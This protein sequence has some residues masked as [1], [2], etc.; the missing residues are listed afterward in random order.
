MSLCKCSG[1]SEACL[2]TLK[3][4]LHP[5]KFMKSVIIGCASREYRGRTCEWDSRRPLG[6]LIYPFR[7]CRQCRQK[8]ELTVGVAENEQT[9]WKA[10]QINEKTTSR[11][12]ML[13]I[14]DGIVKQNEI[15]GNRLCKAVLVQVVSSLKHYLQNK[16]LQS[17]V[18]I[19]LAQKWWVALN[20]WRWMCRQML[21]YCSGTV[22]MTTY[23]FF[24]GLY[25]AGLSD[26]IAETHRW[27]FL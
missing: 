20:L 21:C 2:H 13:V 15:H 3:L 14:P 24:F 11:V 18:K 6:K 7:S 26:C 16:Y 1:A 25:L 12:L 17:T 22:N 8:D 9:E 27:T 23:L 5:G 4:L 10:F 19:S